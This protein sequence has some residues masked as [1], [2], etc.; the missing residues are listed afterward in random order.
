M[1]LEWLWPCVVQ[2]LRRRN[3]RGQC[4]ERFSLAP[5]RLS[6]SKSEQTE[7]N[8]TKTLVIGNRGQSS[9]F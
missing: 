2:D 3:C 5:R 6:N 4:R 1:L 8:Y 7:I 9:D